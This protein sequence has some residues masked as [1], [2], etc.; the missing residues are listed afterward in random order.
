MPGAY[1]TGQEI[2][3]VEEQISE[4]D[5]KGLEE[6]KAGN[7]GP[8]W[9]SGNGGGWRESSCDSLGE[10]NE[11]LGGPGGGGSLVGSCGA[12]TELSS[13]AAGHSKLSAWVPSMGR[14]ARSY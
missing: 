10:A 6:R 7:E 8:V 9:T 12:L 3:R 13:T 14:K 4:T 11:E 1:F 5:K 2:L